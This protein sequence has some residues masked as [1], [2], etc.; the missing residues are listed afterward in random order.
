MFGTMLTIVVNRTLL[1]VETD[2]LADLEELSKVTQPGILKTSLSNVIPGLLDFAVHMVLALFIYL[3]GRKIIKWLRKILRKALERSSIDQGI[4][5]FLD[6]LTKMLLYFV[7]I[8]AVVDQLGVETT[9]VVAVLGSAGLAVGLALQGSLANFAGGVL[10]LIFKPFKVGDYII[11][12][13]RKNEGT[14]KEIMI[15]YTKL[16]TVDNKTV[17]IPNGILANS[18]LTNVTSQEKRMVDL[19]VA[20][21]YDTDIKKAK[22]IL[23]R[24]LQSD[25]AYLE[26]EEVVVFVD[27]LEE[28]GVRLGCRMW[29]KTENY[30]AAKWRITEEIKEQFD[31]NKIEIPFNQLTVSLKQ[32]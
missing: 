4:I 24:I 21:S 10:I 18:S 25:L 32:E 14:V 26:Q 23:T 22:E 16:L 19:Y 17:V 13:T 8:V 20:I 28:S 12:D 1:K 9:S 6:S 11:E 3:V 27:A 31:E 30:W 29:V 7:L 2:Q 15:F 5:Q